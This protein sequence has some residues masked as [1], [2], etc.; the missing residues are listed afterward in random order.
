MFKFIVLFAV[1]TPLIGIWMVENGAYAISV[2]HDGYETGATISY[3]IYAA[4]FF[5]SMLT[6]ISTEKKIK[7]NLHPELISDYEFKQIALFFALINLIF[8][9]V[10]L[11][12]FGAIEVW[13]GAVGKGTFRVGLGFWGAVPNLM[14]KFILPALFA[15]LT[16]LYLRSNK[17][18]HI[19]CLYFFNLILVFLIGSCWGFKSTSFLMLLP[20]LLILHWN[21]R[22]RTLIKISG[23]FILTLIIFFFIFDSKIETNT[24]VFHYL[25]QRATVIQGDVSWYVWSLYKS[26]EEFPNYWPTLLASMGDK[27]LIFSGL[28]DGQ[29]PTNW[30]MYH[31]DWMMNSVAGI[32]LEATLNGHNIIGTPFTEGLI[33]GGIPGELIFALLAGLIVGSMHKYLDR[34][35]HYNRD[36][37]ASIGAT[38]FCFN[39]IPWLSAGAL[40]QLFHISNVI[41]FLITFFIISLIKQVKDSVSEKQINIALRTSEPVGL[42]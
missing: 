16:L 33:A 42:S 23:I 28:L 5:I 21:I 22:F 41:S 14:T 30:M 36:V 40:V 4:L 13:I 26:G 10:L 24:D 32:P 2:G 38:Y 3:A 29:D 12:V 19:K 17:N 8:L 37:G 34:A 25:F 15:Y 7:K 11:F 31:Y 20:S 18:F 6:V 39:I 35:L 27:M 9:L 1:I